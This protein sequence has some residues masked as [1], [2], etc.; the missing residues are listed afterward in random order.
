VVIGLNAEL[1]RGITMNKT[2]RI[3]KNRIF[4]GASKAEDL[5][6]FLFLNGYKCKMTKHYYDEFP[7]V[8]YLICEIEHPKIR[9][10]WCPVNEVSYRCLS[11]YICIEAKELFNKWSQVPIV[12]SIQENFTAILEHLKKM[13]TQEYFD[14]SKSYTVIR[15]DFISA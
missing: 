3:P 5:M 7:D 14:L 12:I 9:A 4:K 11:G 15:N 10:A 2:K 13:E 6:S 1:G 8:Y